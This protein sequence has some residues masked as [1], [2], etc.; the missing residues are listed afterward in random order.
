MQCGVFLLLLKLSSRPSLFSGIEVA[1]THRTFLHGEQC[2]SD[3]TVVI[4]SV[5]VLVLVFQIYF[6]PFAPSFGNIIRECL[7]ADLMLLLG[8]G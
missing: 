1:P 8:S 3:L 4:R 7:T 5:P 2:F 6:L